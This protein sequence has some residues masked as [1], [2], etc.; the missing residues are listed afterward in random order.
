MVPARKLANFCNNGQNPEPNLPG[1]DQ[2]EKA[3]CYLYRLDA[4][5]NK[6]ARAMAANWHEAQTLVGPYPTQMMAMDEAGA[7]IRPPGS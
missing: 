4:P 1:Q 7:A 6:I 2:W 3:I 5:A